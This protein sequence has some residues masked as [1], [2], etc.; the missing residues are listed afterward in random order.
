MPPKELTK[1]SPKPLLKR[2]AA[3]SDSTPAASSTGPTTPPAKRTA[4]EQKNPEAGTPQSS[5][6]PQDTYTYVP[7]NLPDLPEHGLFDDS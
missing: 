4:V 5:D 1:D 3:C 2:P 7:L 6:G